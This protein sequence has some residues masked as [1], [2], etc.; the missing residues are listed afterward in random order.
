MQVLLKMLLKLLSNNILEWLIKRNIKRLNPTST[1]WGNINQFVVF[2][3]DP[4]M[5]EAVIQ[6]TGFY[7]ITASVMKGLS[8][9]LT[10]SVVLDAHQQL[11]CFQLSQFLGGL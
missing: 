3:L 4:F 2:P 10:P 9:A 6:W 7:I 8:R 5:T 11:K 1:T